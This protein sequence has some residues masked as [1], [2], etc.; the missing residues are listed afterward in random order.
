MQDEDDDTRDEQARGDEA[1]GVIEDPQAVYID[2]AIS[3]NA[4]RSQPS[5]PRM[6][7]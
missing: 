7:W 5:S 4:Q 6:H 2:E 3:Q 1:N